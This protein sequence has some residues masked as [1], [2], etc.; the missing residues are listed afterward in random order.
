[1]SSTL[2]IVSTEGDFSLGNHDLALDGIGRAVV[3]TGQAKLV[4]DVQKILFTEFN[5]FWDQ[6]STQ[7]DDLI[8]VNLPINDIMNTLGQ[9]VTDSMVYLQFLQ[10]DQ[11]VY[12]SCS[13]DE[14]I[15]SIAGINVSYAGANSSADQDL[16]T[17]NIAINLVTAANTT[18][19]VS[20][21]YSLAG[22]S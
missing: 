7:F 15:A 2:Q 18:V 21:S 20:Q 9:R 5:P 10:Q 4:Q 14:L 6:Y 1:M 17:F 19:T 16:F 22:S 13:A 12:Q 3:L 8:G 11:R